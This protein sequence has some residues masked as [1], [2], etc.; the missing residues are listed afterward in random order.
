MGATAKS[1][2]HGTKVYSNQPQGPAQFLVRCSTG[3]TGA[4]LA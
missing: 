4:L 1:L 3:K 2:A